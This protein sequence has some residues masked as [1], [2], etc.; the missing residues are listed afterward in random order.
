MS[1]AP[2]AS[3]PITLLL[4]GKP[5][6]G[7]FDGDIASFSL[8]MLG[9]KLPSRREVQRLNDSAGCFAFGTWVVDLTFLKVTGA[10][11]GFAFSPKVSGDLPLSCLN[12][13]EH[14]MRCCKGKARLRYDTGNKELPSVSAQFGGDAHVNIS[15]DDL[16]H[17]YTD[18]A[19]TQ[20]DL[21]VGDGL[22]LRFNL[23]E[24]QRGGQYTCHAAAIVA[25][26][27]DTGEMI[28]SSIFTNNRATEAAAHS[29]RF[30]YVKNAE[31]FSSI[32]AELLPKDKYALGKL[33]VDP[34]S[35]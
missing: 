16:G 35:K 27:N 10:E 15:N 21:A 29:M 20:D 32:Y 18:R 14:M 25:R 17:G 5:A 22:I 7:E 19:F 31:A 8:V 33:A 13:A 34:K 12:S 2:Q 11:G 1:S 9:G 4:E 26:N 30:D 6:S 23:P 28:L 3:T 24:D